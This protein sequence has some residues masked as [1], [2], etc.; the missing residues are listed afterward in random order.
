M[1]NMVN[2]LNSEFI[3]INFGGNIGDQNTYEKNQ[4]IM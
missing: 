2:R 3:W 4:S 1:S